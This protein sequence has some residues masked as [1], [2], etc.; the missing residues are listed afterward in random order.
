M[1]AESAM[2]RTVVARRPRSAN[3]VAAS[4]SSSSRRLIG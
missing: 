4:S 2:S 1:P 3:I